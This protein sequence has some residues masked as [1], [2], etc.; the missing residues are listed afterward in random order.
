L[1]ELEAI[2]F[3]EADFNE[4]P[5]L[6]TKEIGLDDAYPIGHPMNAKFG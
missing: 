1:G 6:E 2:A 3:D 4:S 5:K